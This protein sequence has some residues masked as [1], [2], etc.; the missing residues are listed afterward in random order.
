LGLTRPPT[1]GWPWDQ[2]ADAALRFTEAEQH[3]QAA[4]VA[5]DVGAKAAAE[6]DRE[7]ALRDWQGVREEVARQWVFGLR[8]AL[9]LN[10]ESVRELLS[11]AQRTNHTRG[12]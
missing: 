4:Q 12:R 10:P 2:I 7:T 8:A 6:L 3:L 11:N 5:G 9:D 1:L